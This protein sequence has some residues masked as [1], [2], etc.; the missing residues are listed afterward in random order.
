MPSPAS[1]SG[2]ISEGIM[3]LLIGAHNALQGLAAIF[4]PASW[5][6]SP[7]AVPW[8]EAQADLGGTVSGS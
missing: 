6:S 4:S 7:L 5:P 1:W 2:W 3:M 8:D